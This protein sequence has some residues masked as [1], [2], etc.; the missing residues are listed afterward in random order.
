MRLFILCAF[1]FS[2]STAYAQFGIPCA[3]GPEPSVCGSDLQNYPGKC[4]LDCARQNGK[5]VY[6]I[7]NGPCEDLYN[8]NNNYNPYPPYDPNY[9]YNPYYPY[10]YNP[11]NRYPYY[12]YDPYNPYNP[13][14]PYLLGSSGPKSKEGE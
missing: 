13:Y 10:P 11:Y 14:D 7:Y 12:P 5:N 2:L 1:L 8:N 3:C 6:M 4:N 9:P